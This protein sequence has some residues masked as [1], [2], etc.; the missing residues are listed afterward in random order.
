MDL[1][2][3]SEQEMLR[4]M[5]RG[6]CET[7]SPLTTVR[8]LEDDPTG[9]SPELWKQLAELDLIGLLLPAEYGGSEMSLVEGA[10]VYEELGRGLVPSPHFVSA[11][12]SAG[13]L[14]RAGSAEQKQAWLPGIVSGE[15]IFTIASLEPGN[16]FAPEGVQLRARV[17][18]DGFVLDGTKWHVPYASAATHIVV[19]ARTGDG[20]EDIDLFL[21]DPTA[22][23]VTFTQ[24]LTIASDTQ[25]EVE[26]HGVRVS[27]AD[28]IGGA[29][30]GWATWNATMLE[31][32][33]LLAAQAMGGARYAFDI[34]VQYAKDRE[35]FDKPLG[36]FQAIAHYLADASTTVEGGT[37]LVHEAAWSHANGRPID[38]LAPMAKLY[39]CQTFRD[40]TAMGQQ[41]FG[42]VGF[43]VEYDMQLYFRRA[44]QLQ[45]SWWD[46]RHL[47]ELVAA[48]TLDRDDYAPVRH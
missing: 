24:Q 16:G 19:L 33:V 36:A 25:Y 3:T 12:L 17:D 31:G 22:A 13:V 39:A 46:A 15:E 8:E 11:V 27:A 6:V 7:T 5:V 40:V 23:G 41:V 20:A 37:I 2:F 21:V 28:R 29:G 18:G 45:I 44:K 10:I 38:T 9:F 34:T 47:E 14:V 30:T 42:G 26:L 48:E 35:Q 32:I 43:T 1:D 4:A